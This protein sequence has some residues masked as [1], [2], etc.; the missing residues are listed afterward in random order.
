MKQPYDSQQPL[1][2]N[3]SHTSI[4]MAQGYKAH[5]AHLYCPIAAKA[6]RNVDDVCNKARGFCVC[7]CV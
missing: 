6:D 1:N 3:G 2:A 5:P 7:V 4:K